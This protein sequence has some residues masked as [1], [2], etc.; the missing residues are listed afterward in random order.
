MSYSGTDNSKTIREKMRHERRI[1]QIYRNSPGGWR[2][3]PGPFVMTNTNEIIDPRTRL[4]RTRSPNSP[5]RPVVN[6][7][8]GGPHGDFNKGGPSPVI[9][10]ELTRP[11]VDGPNQWSQGERIAWGMAQGARMIRKGAGLHPVGRAL[12]LI[13]SAWDIWNI[14]N[15]NKKYPPTS[16][17]EIPPGYNFRCG[18]PG[19]N[20][21]VVKG[22]VN[23]D[24]SPTICALT[25]QAVPEPETSPWGRGYFWVNRYA[26]GPSERCDY[27]GIVSYLNTHPGPWP[28]PGP[29]PDVFVPMLTE[30]LPFSLATSETAPQGSDFRWPKP[31]DFPPFKWPDP[32]RPPPPKTKERKGQVA[33]AVGKAV[34][35]AFQVT[36]GVDAV[37]AIYDSLPDHIKRR[38]AKSGKTR[39]GALIGEGVRYST[40]YD[41]AMALYR[42]YRHI[43]LSEAAKNLIINQ[44]VDYLIGRG[45]SQGA[46]KLRKQLGASG[47]GNVI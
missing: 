15:G 17:W 6:I 24:T 42:H 9:Q 3:S 11:P 44:I 46:D 33:T 43:D 23:S 28:T 29:S 47:W 45:S 18:G 26:V 5:N 38:T 12:D 1:T 4:P 25:F 16:N 22:P 32:P 31:P 34:A 35:I 30:P 20:L 13:L 14:I 10:G 40:P 7:Q 2:S 19:G 27:V 39:K 37:E 36:E 41:K 21:L 8:L